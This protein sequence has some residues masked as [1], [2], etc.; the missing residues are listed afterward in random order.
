MC[1]RAK[2][3]TIDGVLLITEVLRPHEG[4]ASR[5]RSTTNTVHSFDVDIRAEEVLEATEQHRR[6]YSI[7]SAL[8]SK[9]KSAL[10]YCIE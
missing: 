3:D 8:I 2:E 1:Q 10:L 6:P 9:Y 5:G 4:N 7:G